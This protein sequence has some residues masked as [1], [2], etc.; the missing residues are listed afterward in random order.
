MQPTNAKVQNMPSMTQTVVSAVLGLLFCGSVSAVTPVHKC[1][2]DGAVTYQSVPCPSGQVG[3]VPTAPQLNDERKKRAAAAGEIAGNR[4]S[5]TPPAQSKASSVSEPAAPAGVAKPR[6]S[7]TQAPRS[8]NGNFGCDARKYCSQ[9]TSCTEAKYFLAN[10]AGVKMD[11]DGN[12]V[13]CEQQW[14]SRQVP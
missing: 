3:P 14:C 4:Q 13:P 1:V 10:C 11:G 9:M 7:A 12:G 6:L 8:L 2:V 5:L